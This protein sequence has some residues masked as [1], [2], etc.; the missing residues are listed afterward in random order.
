MGIQ[1]PPLSYE[2][3]DGVTETKGSMT[4][5]NLADNGICIST[6]STKCSSSKESH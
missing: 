1:Y 3:V 6:V 5:L 2:G 4:K